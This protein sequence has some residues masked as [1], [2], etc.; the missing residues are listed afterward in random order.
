MDDNKISISLGMEG[1]ILNAPCHLVAGMQDGELAFGGVIQWGGKT[2]A[3]VAG[4]SGIAQQEGAG[5]L[6]LELIPEARPQEL[7]VLYQKNILFVGLREENLYF[8]LGKSADNMALLFLFGMDKKQQLNCNAEWSQYIFDCLRAVADFFGIQEFYFYLQKGGQSLLPQMVGNDLVMKQLPSQMSS[9]RMLCHAKLDFNGDSL[10]CKGAST[11]FGVRD[12]EFYLSEREGKTTCLIT[13]PEIKTAYVESHDLAIYLEFDKNVGFF[14][15]GSFVF[16]YLQGMEFIADCGMNGTEFRIEAL[17][18]VSEHIKLFGPFS[19]GDTCLMIQMGLGLEFGFYSTL[20]IGDWNFFGAVML[21]SVGTVI[22]PILLSA[23]MEDISL[24]S[25]LMHLLGEVVKGTECFDILEITG[26]EFQK[27]FPPLNMDNVRAK[28]IDYVVDNFNKNVS[29]K[30]LQLDALQVRITPSDNGANLTDLKRMR[31]YYIGADGKIKLKAQMYYAQ[32]NTHLGDYTIEKGIF[33]CG[34]LIVFNKSFEVL[35]SLR[36]S[37]GI[38]AYARISELDLKFLH[39]GASKFQKGEETKLP[40][41]KNSFLAQFINPT[42]TGV[43]FFLSSGKKEN[44]FYLDGSISVLNLLEVDARIWYMNRNVSVDLSA[45][46]F[47]A[48]RVLLH[49]LV[50]YSSFKDAKFEFAFVFDTA[51]LTEKLHAVTQKVNG[52]IGKLRSKIADAQKE[53]D[54]AQKHVNE[55]Y[56]QIAEFDRKIAEC[57]KAI[58]NASFW[59][60]AF[61]FLG[62]T[63]EIG[64]YE[65]AKLGVYTAIGLATAALDVAKGAVKIAGKVGEAVLKAV[66]AVVEGAMSLFYINYIKLQASADLQQQYMQVEMEFVVIGKTY[67]LSKSLEKKALQDKPEDALA[68]TVNEHIDWDLAHIEEGAFNNTFDANALREQLYTVEESQALLDEATEF[69]TAA[70]DSVTDMQ[71]IYLEEMCVSLEEYDEMN[72]SIMKAMDSVENMM[73]TGTQIGNVN[74]LADAMEELQQNVLLKEKEGANED[75]EDIKGLLKQYDDARMMY[76]KVYEFCDIVK[77]HKSNILDHHEQLNKKSREGEVVIKEDIQDMGNAV[78]RIEERVYEAF[79][80]ER[81]GVFFI[82]PAKEDLLAQYF[83]ELEDALGVKPTDEIWQRRNQGS[84]DAYR[85]RF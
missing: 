46:L 3:D 39:I 70:V 73:K 11:L 66:N 35:F 34:K 65:T 23:A 24:T 75:L 76:D 47:G 69:W 2:L 74:A 64:I 84:D 5:E 71:N 29:D 14:I 37:E 4:E 13:L 28:N 25:L 79:S 18:H 50:D 85:K 27:E 68:G 63:A 82:N 33:L 60:K 12:S 17:A 80:S 32:E 8:K 51:G 67:K 31:H 54:V 59:T 26:L 58:N 45:E 38:V 49:L 78:L 56:N 21:K 61:V 48:F 77:M 41:D 30:M 9:C 81:N 16:P 10:F 44:S 1:T 43:I 7:S 72:V 57:R 42:E 40:I 22:E 15:K 19:I 55:L 6:A 36:E 53:L 20:Y 83:M 52:A 62:K